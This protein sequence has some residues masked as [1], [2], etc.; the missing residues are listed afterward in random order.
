M[1]CC[2]FINVR[3]VWLLVYKRTVCV[4]FWFINAR[5]VWLLV[6]KLRYVWFLEYKRTVCAVYGLWT[7]GMCGFP[8]CRLGWGR[9][10]R[11]R[12]SQCPS[13]SVNIHRCGPAS[14]CDHQ[15]PYYKRLRATNMDFLWKKVRNMNSSDQRHTFMS[16]TELKLCIFF[17]YP[18]VWMFRWI[19]A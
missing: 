18:L 16:K 6:Y 15:R 1:C 17:V 8:C 4:V 2:W 10:C 3:Y 14:V 9:F 5:Y 13:P 11:P 19:C 12:Y 7:Y